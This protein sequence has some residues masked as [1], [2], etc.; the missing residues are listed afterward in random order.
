MPGITRHHYHDLGGGD[1]HLNNSARGSY[2]YNP[3]CD[4]DDCDRDHRYVG[5]VNDY[6]DTIAT[7][8]NNAARHGEGI[9]YNGRV[10]YVTVE[11][12]HGGSGGTPG[13]D[14]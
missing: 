12:D 4:D 2:L 7:F 13:A 6:T 11:H 14:E 3:T 8:L 5:T 10:Y 1:F 9:E